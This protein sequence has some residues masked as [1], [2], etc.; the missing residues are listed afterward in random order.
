MTATRTTVVA[1]LALAASASG[2]QSQTVTPMRVQ[3]GSIGER[4]VV[5]LVVANPY[6]DSRTFQITAFE[7]DGSPIAYW[8]DSPSFELAPAAQKRVIFAASFDGA[9]NREIYICAETLV[10][11]V[12]G[13]ARGQVCSHVWASRLA[14]FR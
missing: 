13:V 14:P 8:T 3:T 11:G 2:V 1:A 12:V 10:E 6:P 7:P 5:R 9:T 4:Y